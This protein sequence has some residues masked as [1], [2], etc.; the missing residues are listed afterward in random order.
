MSPELGPHAQ[1]RSQEVT[2]W[3]ETWGTNEQKTLELESHGERSGHRRPQSRKICPG[4]PSFQ[5]RRRVPHPSLT[6][7]GS[8]PQRLASAEPGSLAPPRVWRTWGPG[9]GGVTSRSEAARG[10]LSE[11]MFSS[12]PWRPLEAVTGVSTGREGRGV[13]PSG[14]EWEVGGRRE[15]K[16][17]ERDS[18]SLGGGD[19]PPVPS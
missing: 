1:P 6:Q 8:N 16:E 19:G 5:A 9:E 4:V 13:M 14:R 2:A 12:V 17:N 3:E 18:P 11:P 7:P 10:P 15:E